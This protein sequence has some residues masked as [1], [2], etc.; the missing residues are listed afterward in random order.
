M[1]KIIILFALFLALPIIAHA[2][3]SVSGISGTVS[4][5]SSVTVSGA[6][7]GTKAQAAPLKWDNF[8]SGAVGSVIGNGSGIIPWYHNTSNYVTGCPGDSCLISGYLPPVYDNTVVRSGSNKSLFC[9]INTKPYQYEGGF[10]LNLTD[11]V[12]YVYISGWRY[13]QTFGPPSRSIKAFRTY[14]TNTNLHPVIGTN[15]MYP[16]GASPGALLFGY[17]ETKSNV[18]WFSEN[19]NSTWK[20]GV[21]E[22]VEY[23]AK[24][25]DPGIANGSYSYAVDG[26]LVA[27][28][29]NVVLRDSASENWRQ[30]NLGHYYAR[31]DSSTPGILTGAGVKYWYD[32]VYIDT[33]QTRVELGNAS[34]WTA[35]TRREIQIPTAWS[36]SSVSFTTNQGAFNSGDQ[37]YVYIVDK[38]GN[39]N[40]NGYP[41]TIGGA[42]T[43]PPTPTTYNLTNFTQLVA[44]WLKTVSS[45]ADVNSD[46]KVNSQD[47]GIMMSNWN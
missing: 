25:S 18:A 44:D 1:K 6:G 8:E 41:V 26:K 13:T 2:A 24:Q 16:Y 28:M 35:S 40:T 19:T 21:W 9:D 31:D 30:I 20:T 43:P 42:V 46:G 34:A 47:L 23:F 11:Q 36:D 33:T 14:G 7:F 32:D 27:S 17:S 22:R 15:Y 5:N 45:P 4:N 38:D 29:S 37:A 10:G 12:P 3:V 39:V